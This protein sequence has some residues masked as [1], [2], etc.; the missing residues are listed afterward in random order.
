MPS[1]SHF[2]RKVERCGIL[3]GV[4]LRALRYFVAVAESGSVSGAASVVHVTQPALSRQVRQLERELAVLLFDRRSGRLEL[5]AAG[6]QFLPIAR[7]LVRRAESVRSAAEAIALGRLARLTIAAPTTTLT[8]V[9]APF[10][11]TFGGSDPLPTVHEVSGSS[12]VELLRQGADLVIVTQ[13]PPASWSVRA[14]AVLPLWAYVPRRHPWSARESV[15]LGELA[16]SSLVVL[17]R[18]FRPRQL[19][20]EALAAEGL[21]MGEYVECG[22]AQVAQALA[23][24]GRG[25]AVVS[26]DSRFELHGARIATAT[27]GLRIRL[28]AAWSPEHHAAALLAEMADR[29]RAFCAERYG[30]GVLPQ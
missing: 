21:A 13:P 22:N 7:D 23:A 19:L 30:R 3:A 29:L 4:E 24:A 28:F 17:D 20:Q 18:S 15:G 5:T 14:L 8:D 25:V 2:A 12:T 9:I 27:G 6:R 16:E 26:D 1:S 11:A 10:L